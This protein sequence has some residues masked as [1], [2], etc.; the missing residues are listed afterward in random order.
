[1][2]IKIFISYRRSDSAAAAGRIYDFLSEEFGKEC[3]FKD[4]INIDYGRKFKKVIRHSIEESQVVLVIIGKQFITREKRIFE[5]KDYVRFE[6]AYALQKGKTVIPVIVDDA[7]FPK[8]ENLPE[9]IK[10]LSTINGPQLRDS[11]WTVDCEEF[12]QKLKG[13]LDFE[14]PI[15]KREASFSTSE[16]LFTHKTGHRL[17]QYLRYLCD[18]KDQV[19]EFHIKF[20]EALQTNPPIFFCTVHGSRKQSHHGLFRRLDYEYFWNED[21]ED[22]TPSKIV[23]IDRKSDYKEYQLFLLIKLFKVFGEHRI[24]IDQ[25]NLLNFIKIIRKRGYKRVAIHF[26][27][28]SSRWKPET[29]K[30]IKWLVHDFFDCSKVGREIPKIYCFIHVIYDMSD[31]GPGGFEKYLRYRAN[32]ELKIRKNI[33]QV[34]GGLNVFNYVFLSE[35]KPITK[36]E[37]EDWLDENLEFDLDKE[38]VLRKYFPEK[39]G[40]FDMELIEAAL[41]Q[42]IEDFNLGNGSNSFYS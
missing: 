5:K 25:M 28:K 26:K 36:S 18:R 21:Q 9:E 7:E 11:K 32:P 34:L 2:S 37:I 31:E 38:L 4:V 15:F 1:M 33:Q 14:K 23:H 30:L 40:F 10:V 27:V 29:A 19:H 8:P 39:S 20:N 6:I 22:W 13:I 16:D 17:G 12:C 24:P 3:I 35:L 42:I 41:D